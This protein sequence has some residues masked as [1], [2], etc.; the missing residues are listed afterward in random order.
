MLTVLENYYNDIS[1]GMATEERKFSR[2]CEAH[3]SRS[4]RLRCCTCSAPAE[5]EWTRSVGGEMCCHSLELIELSA[6]PRAQIC[7][8]QRFDRFKQ[9]MDLLI[10]ARGADRCKQSLNLKERF[11]CA[12]DLAS[13]GSPSRCGARERELPRIMINANI[14]ASELFQSKTDSRAVARPEPPEQMARSRSVGESEMYAH[15]QLT[16]AQSNSITRGA[17]KREGS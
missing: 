7:A 17:A 10:L 6:S 11:G 14:C 2:V 8:R 1:F 12:A 3:L 15:Q 9:F 4:V 13:F 16:R 5:R